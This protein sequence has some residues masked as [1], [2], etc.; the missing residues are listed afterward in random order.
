MQN[1]GTYPDQ[2]SNTQQGSGNQQGQYPPQEGPYMQ[3]TNSYENPTYLA[4]PGN[5]G[6]YFPPQQQPL[7][8]QPPQPESKTTPTATLSSGTPSNLPEETKISAEN[9]PNVKQG[10][11]T[12]QEKPE[13]KAEVLEQKVSE[14]KTQTDKAPEIPP[15]RQN[16]IYSHY[17]GRKQ[18]YDNVMKD[19]ND[20]EKATIYSN[21][22]AAMKYLGVKYVKDLEESAKKYFPVEPQTNLYHPYNNTRSNQDSSRYSQG[23]YY[24]NQSDR[25]SPNR[26]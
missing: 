10:T 17:S 24:Q 15:R 16:E 11:N 18:V 7:S 9:L 4:F 2:S 26:Y 25:R 21:V 8:T 3:P 20:P 6:K 5:Y 23:R 13:Q 12:E 19:L 22:W 1:Q 14:S